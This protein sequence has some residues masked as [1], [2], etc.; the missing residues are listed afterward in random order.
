M[1]IFLVSPP[2]LSAESKPPA[3]SEVAGTAEAE[4]DRR[5]RLLADA[6]ALIEEGDLL[7]GEG[8]LE[9]AMSSF[10][11]AAQILPRSPVTDSVRTH[12][13]TRFSET[14]VQHARTL[15]EG[16]HAGEAGRLLEAVL[17]KEMNPGYAPAAELLSDLADPQIVNPGRTPEHVRDVSEVE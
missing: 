4:I 10:S 11:E 15:V 16:G 6:T 14:A 12:A 9:A 1:V 13:I 2:T 5:G 7:A 3:P 17:V 8:S